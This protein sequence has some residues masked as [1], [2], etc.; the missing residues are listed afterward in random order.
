MVRLRFLA[1]IAAFTLSCVMSLHSLPSNVQSQ[2]TNADFIVFFRDGQIPAYPILP[3][4]AHDFI[5]TNSKSEIN[6]D[7]DRAQGFKPE[8]I[9]YL[10]E[11]ILGGGQFRVGMYDCVKMVFG[12]PFES[13]TIKMVK[14]T[15]PEKEPNF[16]PV[17]MTM[18]LTESVAKAGDLFTKLETVSHEIIHAFSGRYL[19]RFDNFE[20][21]FAVSMTVLSGKMF[22]DLNSISGPIARTFSGI[23]VM[24]RDYEIYNQPA[25]SPPYGQF[26]RTPRIID[27]GLR[28]HLAGVAWHKIWRETADQ[29][30]SSWNSL[31]YNGDEFFAVFNALLRNEIAVNPNIVQNSKEN[32]LVLKSLVGKALIEIKGNDKI[33]DENF[34]DWWAKQFILS[35]NPLPG[36]FLYGVAPLNGDTPNFVYRPWPN[37]ASKCFVRQL[38]FFKRTENGDEVATDGNLYVKITSLN[39][40]NLYF[41]QDV[42][43]SVVCEFASEDGLFFDCSPDEPVL[44]FVAAKTYNGFE[45]NFKNLPTGAYKMELEAKNVGGLQA[46]LDL[47]F[48]NKILAVPKENRCVVIF[49]NETLPNDYFYAN[50]TRFKRSLETEK[51][52]FA[53]FG[54]EKGE[55]LTFE[56]GNLLI[57]KQNLCKTLFAPDGHLFAVF[58]GKTSVIFDAGLNLKM[59]DSEGK[60]IQEN[61]TL[62]GDKL[63]LSA[64][65]PYEGSFLEAVVYHTNYANQ[66]YVWGIFRSEVQNKESQARIWLDGLPSGEFELMARCRAMD[67]KSSQWTNKSSKNQELRFKVQHKDIIDKL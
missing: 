38:D 6:F 53:V 16:N 5:S 12:S 56:A 22:C 43:S 20:E 27:V 42:T 19:K 45:L 39:W 14:T 3:E 63:T 2:E 8:E 7:F 15:D 61:E 17:T 64:K 48:A 54:F 47:Y 44:S 24:L 52:G 34:D 51:Y 30:I 28:Y 49:D 40:N 58:K 57:G 59:T 67:G 46:K 66:K 55:K 9:L 26:W 41:G 31:T 1:F 13:F 25:V 36:A 4:V 29:T 37:K 33:E 18:T 65:L 10:K 32:F 23:P 60:D 62:I 21:G 50:G 11:F 35:Y